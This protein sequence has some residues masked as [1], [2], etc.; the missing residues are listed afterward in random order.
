MTVGVVGGSGFNGSHVVDQLVE[1]GHD[2]TVFD[3]M[4]P[5][6]NDVRHVIIDVLDLAR[7]V[8]AL[9]GPYDTVYQLAAMANVNDVYRSPVEAGH[10]KVMAV[11]NVL[12]ATRR[13]DVGR[14][15]LASTVWIH[16]RSTDTEVDEETQ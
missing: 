15:V 1:K 2:V 3:I 9:A 14:V 4:T 16:D 6:R 10:V 11:A 13:N 5:D 8:M 7:T 12:E